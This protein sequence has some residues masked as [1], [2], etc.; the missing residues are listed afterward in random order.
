MLR[1]FTIVTQA[2]LIATAAALR[3]R[4][5]THKGPSPLP[6]GVR[7]ISGSEGEGAK[8]ARALKALSAQTVSYSGWVC[9]QITVTDS[10]V[11]W[12]PASSVLATVAL[13]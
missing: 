11:R 7:Q 4:S 2:S 1:L 9:G 13:W 3:Q 12:P 10:Q 6:P 5:H 8:A